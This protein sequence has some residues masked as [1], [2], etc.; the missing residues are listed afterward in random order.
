MF[1]SIESLRTSDLCMLQATK[2]KKLK[3][4]IKCDKYDC[5][6]EFSTKCGASFCAK[7]RL[8][9]QI[10]NV[11]IAV[12][13]EKATSNK[14]NDKLKIRKY[15]LFESDINKCKSSGSYEWK[16]ENACMNNAKCVFSQCDCAGDLAFKCSNEFCTSDE[17]T[18]DSML[19]WINSRSDSRNIT[20][21]LVAKCKN[22]SAENMD[23]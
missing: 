5:G 18:C 21:N 2:C 6:G 13:Q 22:D 14:M 1:K 9:C 12:V 15:R 8:S 3:N 11:W 16:L 10:F 20:A 7:D 19:T 23:E 17:T 4:I